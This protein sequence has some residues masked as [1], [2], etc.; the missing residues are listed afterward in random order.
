MNPKGERL[1]SQGSPYITKSI[2]DP[3]IFIDLDEN[4]LKDFN[5]KHKYLSCD[6]LEYIYAGYVFYNKLIDFNGF[7]L[8]ASA[9]CVDEKAYLFSAPSGTGKSTHAALWQQYLGDRAIIINDDKPAIRLKDDNFFV[10]G[11]PF[12][13][14]TNL[15][16]NVC[17]EL[18]AICI[19]ERGK[20]NRVERL[21]TEQ[22]IFPILN[23]TL[24]PREKDK[25]NALLTLLDKCLRKTKVFK[26]YCN[27]DIEAAKIAYATMREEG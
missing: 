26:L 9:V 25:M 20:T 14:K 24:R 22:A 17:V 7:F 5:D 18:G 13:G 27:M 10:Y 11:T 3:D 1:I 23:Q 19:L 16:H 2:D 21:S 8:H 15:N 6:E 4:I 12:S